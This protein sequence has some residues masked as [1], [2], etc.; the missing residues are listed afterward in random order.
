MKIPSQRPQLAEY[1]RDQILTPSENARKAGSFD[2]DYTSVL[3]HF[4][5]KA[6]PDDLSENELWVQPGVV[7]PTL[8]PLEGVITRAERRLTASPVGDEDQEQAEIFRRVA[9]KLMENG[10]VY[11]TMT[12]AAMPGILHGIAVTRS[13]V[14]KNR[15]VCRLIQ[16]NKITVD[17]DAC[18]PNL[19]DRRWIIYSDSL[20]FDA[21]RKR[22]G[23][24]VDSAANG[25]DQ[26]KRD[27]GFHEIEWWCPFDGKIW[28][29]GKTGRINLEQPD[30]P[31]DAVPETDR[32]KWTE[33]EM[34]ADGFWRLTTL[35]DTGA[36]DK[37]VVD[38]KPTGLARSIYNLFVLDV[39]P[40]EYAFIGL[41]KRLSIL[42]DAAA[43]ALTAGIAGLSQGN[44]FIAAF[45]EQLS[46]AQRDAIADRQPVVLDNQGENV[47]NNVRVFNFPTQGAEKALE[48]ANSLLQFAAAHAGTSDVLSGRTPVRPE[49]GVIVDRLTEAASNNSVHIAKRFNR[50]A[51]A[52]AKTHAELIQRKIPADVIVRIA[53]PNNEEKSLNVPV[54]VEPSTTSGDQFKRLGNRFAESLLYD[55]SLTV[56]IEEAIYRAQRARRATELIQLD[57][58]DLEAYLMMI[59]DPE[60][61]A[62]L[63]GLNER[64]K[65]RGMVEFIMTNPRAAMLIEGLMSQQQLSENR[66]SPLLQNPNGESENAA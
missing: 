64:D 35:L 66:N 52:L 54:G 59:R 60:S 53:D 31:G 12:D 6:R 20:D 58:I 44:A 39:D 63:K 38:D 37:L 9:D 25:N 27:V 1:L 41:G 51:N 28:V 14:S 29:D 61:Q 17:P 11:Y 10:D 34:Q 3:K 49:S 47:H 26:G 65:A 22:W 42:E 62:I 55:L 48:L 4:H 32:I 19:E 30:D 46:Q 15:L 7:Y 57:K 13:T 56:D 8:I 36:Q 45:A 43:G 16:P 50:F 23:D 18:D 21:A 40:D 2:D 5:A 24:V 33:I